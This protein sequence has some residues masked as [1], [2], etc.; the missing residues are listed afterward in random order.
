[1]KEEWKDIKGYEGLYQ[2]SN[3]GRVK[4]LDREVIHKNGLIKLYK[5]RVLINNNLTKYPSIHLY[6]NGKVKN[7][8]IHRLVAQAFI[9]NTLNK[10]EV[11]HINGIKK[12]NRV[13]NLEWCTRSE[14]TIHAYKTGL[15]NG[16]HKKKRVCLIENDKI[17]LIFDSIK[18]ACYATNGERHGIG[19]ACAGKVHT[20]GGY[21]WKFL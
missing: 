4:S 2:V 14:N 19:R 1:M 3:K 15:Q 6:L 16:N 10:L 11:N 7:Y 18:E 21:K 20:S 9:L 13:E 5:G 12:D 17:L 8:L